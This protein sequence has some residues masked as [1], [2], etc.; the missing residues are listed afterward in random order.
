VEVTIS[1]FFQKNVI[2]YR[3]LKSYISMKQDMFLCASTRNT[4]ITEQVRYFGR[5]PNTSVTTVFRTSQNMTVV[6]VCK[7][8]LSRF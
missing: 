5:H 6:V 3:K 7:T 2:E 4:V 1:C 8:V